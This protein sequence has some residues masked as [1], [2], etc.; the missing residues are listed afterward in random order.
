MRW[1]NRPAGM[2]S[3]GAAFCRRTLPCPPRENHGRLAA[4]REEA[5]AVDRAARTLVRF[6]AF[7]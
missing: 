3:D 4:G 1:I 7:Q 6:C 5:E 2:F